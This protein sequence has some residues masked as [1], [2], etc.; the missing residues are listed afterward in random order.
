MD[1]SQA[2]RMR[3]H[4]KNKESG[5]ESHMVHLKRCGR[6]KSDDMRICESQTESPPERAVWTIK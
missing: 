1:V 2:E 4:G 3:S 5:Q 6:Q